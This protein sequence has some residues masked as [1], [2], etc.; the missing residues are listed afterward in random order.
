MVHAIRKRRKTVGEETVSDTGGTKS[1]TGS[2]FKLDN[3][4]WIN[5][6]KQKCQK[7]N[8]GG[9]KKTMHEIR[10]S[11]S[12]MSR[13]EKSHYT[14]HKNEVVEDKFPVG[15]T[16]KENVTLPFH[17]RCT[18]YTFFSD[19]DYLFRLA[20]GCCPRFR[21]DIS[22]PSI[23]LHGKSF[24]LDADV[25]SHVMG[26]SNIEERIS[27]DRPILKSWRS[28]FSITSCGIKL[29]HLDN[30]LKNNKTADDDF[31]V[32]FCLHMLGT[33]LAP[34]AGEYVDARYLTVLS[35]VVSIKGKNWARWCFDQL[36]TSIQKFQ[37]KSARY[38]G[39]CV[40][41]LELFYLH[42]IDWQ[43]SV[44]D[45]LVIPIVSWTSQHIKKCLKQLR[46]Q[47]SYGT[48]IKV[49]IKEYTP[50]A[51][52]GDNSDN[53]KGDIPK[54][55][56]FHLQLKEIQHLRTEQAALK[57]NVDISFKDSPL[58]SK[59][60]LDNNSPTCSLE[61]DVEPTPEEGAFADA[62]PVDHNTIPRLVDEENRSTTAKGRAEQ[63]STGR[64]ST[65]RVQQS[66]M[67]W[68][69]PFHL[70]VSLNALDAQVINYMFSE[71][72]PPS[73]TIVSATRIIVNR[74]SFRTLE[75]KVWV[76]SE[77]I[78]LVAENNTHVANKKRS[79]LYC[80]DGNMKRL[81]EIHSTFKAD[82]MY[83][84]PRCHKIYIPI[85]N[86]KDHWYLTLVHI[87]KSKVEI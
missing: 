65:H 54:D 16:F 67:F 26:I 12:N 40:L 80:K 39:G 29:V 1:S 68:Y 71:D 56:G 42:V 85:N 23:E 27:I 11:W 2:K 87:K 48:N 38:I 18:P 76:D 43:P 50:P 70:S 55:D 75:P 20:K 3:M 83:D 28:K 13:E 14:M 32:T 59:D 78:S 86:L 61:K 49:C 52:Y 17:T 64:N 47:G 4:A 31:K 21:F 45:K 30:L 5:F 72:L 82:Y 25:F 63:S 33:V 7:T 77:I 9:T 51:A 57:E 34:T 46:E 84:L 15:D 37:C 10:T 69:V 24:K 79:H 62:H 22:N 19:D 53:Q 74:S 60:D 66:S 73:E 6:H 35:D 36:V 81:I 8:I 58:N 41:F 44:V